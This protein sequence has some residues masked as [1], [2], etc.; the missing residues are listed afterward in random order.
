MIRPIENANP[1]LTA[2]K[3]L[4]NIFG[5]RN[6]RFE[7]SVII[8]SLIAGND[9]FVLMPTGSGKS[10]CYQIPALIRQG[11]AIVIS[12][13]IS[14]MQDQV[15]ALKVNGVKAAFY[16]SSL[17]FEAA[18]NV[19]FQL[20]NHSLDLLYISPERLLN[21][22]FIE[23]L[24]T[25]KIALFAIDEAHCIS[26]WGHDFRPEYVRLGQIRQ[27][28]SSVPMI[29]L[30]A[31][32][33]KQTQEDICYRL[34]LNNAQ[35]HVAS[36]DRPNLSYSIIDK[37]KPMTQLFSFLKERQNQQGIV[38]CHSRRK[39]EEINAKLKQAGIKTLPYHAGLMPEDRLYAQQA[40]QKDEIQVVVATI[41][42]GMGINKLNVRFV[43]H[44]DMPKHIESYYQETGR[45][46]RDGLPAECLLLFDVS[47]ISQLQRLIEKNENLQQKRIELHKLKAMVAFA[48]A[49]TCR[50]KVLLNYFGE[51][52]NADCGN[53]DICLNPPE[54]Y[55]ATEDARKAL[56]CVYRVGQ[57]FGIRHIIEVLRGADTQYIKSLKHDDL[58]TYGIGQYLTQ[59]AWV[60]IFRQLIH[61]GY[62][63]QDIS[64]SS[65][66]HLTEAA[67][68]LLRGDIKIHLAKPRTLRKTR[69]HNTQNLSYDIV[70]F[71]RLCQVR[72]ELALK[73]NIPPFIIFSDATL[74][75]MA[76]H[77]PLTREG[78]IAINGVGEYKLIRYGEN[79]IKEINKFSLLD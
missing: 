51:V 31:T 33:D 8:E 20:H 41:A 44:Y 61:Q 7:Q 64:H 32:A 39:V 24:K 25:I 37:Y 55:E 66:L 15:S 56:S 76:I 46:G 54:K 29:A 71:E 48:E 73:E 9:N 21:P 18:K 65:V 16:N 27:Y 74:V 38:Y 35:I 68:P 40:F 58:S 34:G 52:L 79:F 47:D 28:F 75:E 69:N 13:L 43:I 36:F 10:L 42:F 57:K 53:C 62:L 77:R 78:F 3:I 17:D 63:A 4:Q 45:A 60:S 50:R 11:V 14:L 1:T 59:E 19:L 26:Q 12:P 5:Y 2:K 72:K 22:R 30:T 70:L 6:F 49:E 23:R 67:R